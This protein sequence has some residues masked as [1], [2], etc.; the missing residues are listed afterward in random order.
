MAI[1]PISSAMA[2]SAQPT[3]RT[4]TAQN[5]A[6]ESTE[7][8]VSDFNAPQIDAET[9]SVSKAQTEGEENGESKGGQQQQPP[10][11]DDTIKKALEELTKKQA[12]FT[13]EFGIHEKTNRITVKIVDKDT[14]EVIKELPPEK[15][16][17]MIAKVW[18]YA[19]LFVD[20]KRYGGED[21]SSNRLRVTGMI[22]GMDTESI[23]NAYATPA[24][25]R[26]EKAKKSK[27]LNTWTQDAWKGL[28]TKIYS[29][30]SKTLSTNRMSAAYRKTKT[31]TS[32]GALTVTAGADTPKGVQT[33][34]IL[35]TAKA[36]YLTGSEVKASSELTGDESLV[37]ALGIENGT[38][39]KFTSGGKD[40]N[41]VIAENMSEEDRAAAE[42]DGKQ[43]V[44]SMKD[45]VN[46]LKKA[47]VNA[48]FDTANQ[49]LFVS[50]KSTGEK[51]DFSI[52][53]DFSGAGASRSMNALAKLGLA[54]DDVIADY[55]KDQKA[56]GNTVT[57][58]QVKTD[59][60]IKNIATKIDG[61][62]A[63]IKVNGAEF[64]SATNTFNIN[65]STFEVNYIDRK[66][67][68]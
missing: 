22:S 35:N 13:S 16:L 21:M 64:K 60:G 6:N 52:T 34:Q 9:L 15:M 56:A 49:R 23:I 40:T 54:G 14:K 29:F 36:A 43:V 46:V 28:N 37:S 1:E 63:R 33:A 8:K 66:S 53:A 51:N 3:V 59:F 67:V 42:A 31:T 27:Q 7:G 41:I 44:S 5:T 30:Y 39:I 55:I 58:E 45:L 32:N 19:G 4:E 10:M 57:A 12:N 26:L 62:D 38:E 25:T 2:Y 61:E 47:G 48:N 65:G 20:E 17:D 18:E 11:N 50:A 24:K 68:V